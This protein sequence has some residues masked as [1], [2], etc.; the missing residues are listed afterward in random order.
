MTILSMLPSTIRILVFC[1]LFCL[2][3]LAAEI[4]CWS[5]RKPSILEGKIAEW[6]PAPEFLGWRKA[7]PAVHGFEGEVLA[8]TLSGPFHSGAWSQHAGAIFTLPRTFQPE[9]AFEVHFKARSLT[10]PKYL[11]VLRSW[12]GAKP[13]SPI[14]ITESWETYRVVLTPQMPTERLTFS[15]V[16]KPGGLQPYCA[17]TFEISG[18]AV[19]LCSNQ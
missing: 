17:G 10:G 19:S 12:G 1:L 16:P 15:L 9:E 6:L 8:V 11:S 13:W 7:D 3:G 2:P 18:V 5:A 4:D 14:A